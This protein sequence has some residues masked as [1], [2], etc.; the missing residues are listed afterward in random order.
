[1]CRS[2]LIF[3]GKPTHDQI[4]AWFPS[5]GND[6][7]P[8]KLKIDGSLITDELLFQYFYSELVLAGLLKN[9][10]RGALQVPGISIEE[11]HLEMDLPLGF[12]EMIK[13]E[14]EQAARKVIILHETGRAVLVK[15]GTDSIASNIFYDDSI[16]VIVGNHDGFPEHIEKELLETCD[17]VL[18][19]SA[20]T[21]V[22]GLPVISYLGSHV[23]DMVHYFFSDYLMQR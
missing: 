22:M 2:C 16:D 6:N 13:Q 11:L 23:I 12:L 4:E 20:I 1:M 9:I 15:T 5:G 18:C 7:F 14:K 3:D 21:P 10:M 19:M 17:H 8:L